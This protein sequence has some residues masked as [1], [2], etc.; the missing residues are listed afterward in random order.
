MIAG[1]YLRSLSAGFP[2]T[3]GGNLLRF[4]RRRA[5]RS[6]EVHTGLPK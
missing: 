2:E 5:L 4:K 3:M 1:S 6:D